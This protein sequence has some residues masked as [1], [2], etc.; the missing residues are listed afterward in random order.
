MT[1]FRAEFSNVMQNFVVE[2]SQLGV[3]GPKTGVLG[4]VKIS[5]V[6]IDSVSILL[7]SLTMQNAVMEWL[8]VVAVV[9]SPAHDIGAEMPLNATLYSFVA[10]RLQLLAMH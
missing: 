3:C 5:L 2:H 10:F 9:C 1:K 4:G 8:A 7:L 6:V